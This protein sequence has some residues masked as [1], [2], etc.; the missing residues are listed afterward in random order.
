MF[1]VGVLSWKAHDTLRKTLSSYRHLLPLVDEAVVFFN[2]ISDED[3]GIAREFGFRDEGSSENLGIL[4]GTLSLVRH[5]HGDVVMLLQND[6]PINV[7]S[8]T[9]A[10]RIAS[11]RSLIDD[12]VADIVRM[13]DRFDPTF[14][15]RMK[16]LRYWPDENG[17]DTLKLRVRR[18]LRPFKALRMAGR[19]PD[20]LQNPSVRH[21][22]IFSDVS[23]AFVSDSRYVNYS[24]QPLMVRRS[25]ILELLEWADAHKQGRRTLNGL[26]V[27][28]IIINGAYWRRRKVRIAITDGVFAHARFDDSFRP[29]NKAFNSAIASVHNENRHI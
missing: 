16:Y 23:G 4:G 6:N 18:F 29:D 3:R 24:D 7:S 8:D 12:G 17:C 27:P 28:E 15:D 1:S 9:L 25:L 2:S 19:A 5:L 26:A 14:S 13:R 20:V 22:R 21:S 10:K 11:A